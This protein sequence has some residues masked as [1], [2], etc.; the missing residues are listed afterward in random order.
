MTAWA[1]E[2]CR[3]LVLAVQLLTRIPVRAGPPGPGDLARALRWAPLVGAGVGWA[4]ALVL[5]IGLPPLLAAVAAVGVTVLLT[6]GLHED[7]L[8]DTLDGLGGGR[9]REAALRIMKDSRI[10]AYGALGLV[11]V[12][13]GRVAALA[14]LPGM[15]M[16]GAH[17]LSRLAMLI[18]PATLAPARPGGVGAPVSGGPGAAGWGVAAVTVLLAWAGQPRLLAAVVV[19]VGA[20]WLFARHVRRRLGGYTGDTLG[21]VQQGTELLAYLVLAWRGG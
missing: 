18:L 13:A 1:R 10:G 7:G 17:A 5:G 15:A 21:A 9:T 2:Q 11:L 16:V 3:L 8:A 4:G 12:T 14:V 19:C 6:G 20:A